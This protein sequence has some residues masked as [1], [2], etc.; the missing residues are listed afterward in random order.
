MNPVVAAC[1]CVLMILYYLAAS[2]PELSVPMCV[3]LS[4]GAIP[5]F[6]LVLTAFSWIAIAVS[7]RGN[8]LVPGSTLSGI[9]LPEEII[10]RTE[11]LEHSRVYIN[12]FYDGEDYTVLY[13][14][15]SE[16]SEDE[17]IEVLTSLGSYQSSHGGK[18]FQFW[19]STTDRKN[20]VYPPLYADLQ[21]PMLA[22]LAKDPDAEISK[23]LK[24]AILRL[25]ERYAI[26][27]R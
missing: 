9:T 14:L 21:Y 1:F 12:Q 11:K 26:A 18:F 15:P 24:Y 7:S 6:F 19:N 23:K 3:L 8:L 2:F 16:L 20:D 4:F 5:I 13:T 17:I 22:V 10:E 25:K 27:E